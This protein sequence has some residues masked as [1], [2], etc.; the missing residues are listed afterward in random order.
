MEGD[1]TQRSSRNESPMEAD[2]FHSHPP[3]NTNIDVLI[4][5]PREDQGRNFMLSPPPQF[6]HFVHRLF[7]TQSVSAA[8]QIPP[9][10]QGPPTRPPSS[11]Q[12]SSP[13]PIPS[14]TPPQP[15]TESPGL[16]LP[17]YFNAQYYRGLPGTLRTQEAI[18]GQPE[19]KL[20]ADFLSDRCERDNLVNGLLEDILRSARLLYN[21]GNVDV[22]LRIT[23]PE[24]EKHYEYTSLGCQTDEDDRG[25]I[26]RMDAIWERMSNRRRR[27]FRHRF[28]LRGLL[29][30]P[31]LALGDVAKH[32]S[33]Q[34]EDEAKLLRMT[35]PRPY[36]KARIPLDLESVLYALDAP[37]RA[38]VAVELLYSRFVGRFEDIPLIPHAVTELG[39]CGDWAQ[40]LVVLLMRYAR[41][42]ALPV[43]G[44]LLQFHPPSI[45]KE[46]LRS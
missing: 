3:T 13:A 18:L 15:P 8:A 39:V 1:S 32:G 30:D 29:R 43:S 34:Q 26:H 37:I 45:P 38:F 5:P 36:L 10:T 44:E 17:S 2:P 33:T 42:S 19:Y 7:S 35:G 11:T 24:E 22:Y 6:P 14:S 12:P 20:P 46:L 28:E 21:R 25:L 40:I 4:A 27:V 41:S 31:P 23:R 9:F 16:A